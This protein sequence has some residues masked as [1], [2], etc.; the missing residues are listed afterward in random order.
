M[1]YSVIKLCFVVLLLISFL[2]LMA[3]PSLLKFLAGGVIIEVSRVPKQ[4]NGKPQ[5]QELE[6]PAL[7]FC[8][9]NLSSWKDG[10]ATKDI[11][12]SN[13][14]ANCGNVSMEE[15]MNCIQEKTFSIKDTVISAYHD[16]CR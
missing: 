15:L 7:T 10:F 6:S 4:K 9:K 2:L 3:W 8:A 14:A 13:V 16:Q 1:F 11:T 5:L 12:T